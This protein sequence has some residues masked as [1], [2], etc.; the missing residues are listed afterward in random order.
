MFHCSIWHLWTSILTWLHKCNACGNVAWF[1]CSWVL[2]FLKLCPWVKVS[3]P[4]KFSQYPRKKGVCMCVRFMDFFPTWRSRAMWEKVVC[5]KAFTLLL[6]LCIWKTSYSQSFVM[7]HSNLDVLMDSQ[8][9]TCILALTTT[10][11]SHSDKLEI[12]NRFHIYRQKSYSGGVY[13]HV[14]REVG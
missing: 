14:K 5:G 6:A 11:C 9:I 1:F 10:L 8:V 2:L 13:K 7:K 12:W 3:I 4:W